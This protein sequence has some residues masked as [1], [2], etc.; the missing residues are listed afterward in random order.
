MTRGEK[1]SF[2]SFEKMMYCMYT[3]QA[4]LLLAVIWA[5]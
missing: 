3:I 2:E 4:L 1:N 5:I